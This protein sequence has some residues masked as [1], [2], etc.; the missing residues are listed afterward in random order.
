[1]KRNF[2]G[3][4]NDWTYLK[5]LPS[6]AVSPLLFVDSWIFTN[7]L[8]KSIISGKCLVP[9]LD[10]TCTSSGSLLDPTLNS[11]GLKR[12]NHLWSLVQ[13]PLREEESSRV[14]WSL[15]VGVSWGGQP[16]RKRLNRYFFRGEE[17]LRSSSVVVDRKAFDVLPRE[18]K[19]ESRIK[20]WGKDTSV[21]LRNCIKK[22]PKH[23]STQRN[24]DSNGD[25]KVV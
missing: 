6:S 20:V 14:K 2:F 5:P 13:P 23:G 7:K 21:F 12:P 17:S 3:G 9:Q 15:V 22:Y 11:Q 18:E 25:S 4:K 16:W 10:V 24:S 1:M 8:K 19:L